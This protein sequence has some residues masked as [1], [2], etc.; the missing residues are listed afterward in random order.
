MLLDIECVGT[1]GE[2]KL[3]I[4]VFELIEGVPETDPALDVGRDWGM[5]A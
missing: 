3:P 1:L 2:F 4:N 5:P